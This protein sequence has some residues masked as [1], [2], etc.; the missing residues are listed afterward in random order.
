MSKKIKEMAEKGVPIEELGEIMGLDRIRVTRVKRVFNL[1]D[2]YKTT[3]KELK[4]LI[5][6]IYGKK[7]YGG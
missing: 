7:L 6:K 3:E 1:K 2:G 5:E 4:R